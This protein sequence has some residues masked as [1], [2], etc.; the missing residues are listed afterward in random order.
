L[1]QAEVHYSGSSLY[2]VTLC[3]DKGEKKSCPSKSLVKYTLLDFL[4]KYRPYLLERRERYVGLYEDPLSPK[5]G[6]IIN[7]FINLDS[8]RIK[9]RIYMYCI[10]V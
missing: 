6:I 8:S 1:Y 7:P 5:F 3:V 4:E 2:E 10:Y 9:F